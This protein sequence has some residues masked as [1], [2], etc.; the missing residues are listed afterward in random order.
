[1]SLLD[2]S[3]MHAAFCL[4]LSNTHVGLLLH[5]VFISV[6]LRVPLESL[7]S[8]NH[9]TMM[10][11]RG[12]EMS[13]A[14]LCCCSLFSSVMKHNTQVSTQHVTRQIVKCHLAMEANVELQNLALQLHGDNVIDDDDLFLLLD[15]HRP[16]RNLHIDVPYW[17]YSLCA[18]LPG[19]SELTGGGVGSFLD[20]QLMGVRIS[21]GGWNCLET[22]SNGCR[23]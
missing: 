19:G 23:T 9:F 15:A 4:G 16:R 10:T 7:Q 17:C 2:S 14:G 3:Q 8:A 12:L 13:T 1:M 20:I 22:S 11:L 21:G 5:I 18:Y 6:L